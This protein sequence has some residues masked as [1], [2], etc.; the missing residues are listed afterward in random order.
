MFLNLESTRLAGP[1]IRHRI[2]L[3]VKAERVDKG[4][5]VGG[6]LTSCDGDG[7]TVRRRVH[8]SRT[9]EISLRRIRPG[10]F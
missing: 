5:V 7:L 4:L 2:A 9:G 1:R 3:V 10:R 8:G 6:V